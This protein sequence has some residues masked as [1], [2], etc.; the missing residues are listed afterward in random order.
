MAFGSRAFTRALAWSSTISRH[1]PSCSVAASS[2]V[3]R[4]ARARSA[5]RAA[6]DPALAMAASSLAMPWRSPCPS[7]WAPSLLPTLVSTVVLVLV[8]SVATVSSSV[9]SSSSLRPLPSTPASSSLQSGFPAPSL[10]ALAAA[11]VSR[12]RWG[13]LRLLET[14]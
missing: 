4:L 6:V 10:A 2:A 5:N 8:P 1:T 13:E 11:R 14:L 7:G 9:S 12:F 3:A